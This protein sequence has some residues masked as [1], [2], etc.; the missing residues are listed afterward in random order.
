MEARVPLQPDIQSLA[1]GLGSVLA[2]QNASE[3]TNLDRERNAYSSGSFSEIV[4]CQ[5]ADGR[6]LRLFFKYA[7]FPFGADYHDASHEPFE[8]MPWS[9]VPYE[10][11]VYRQVLEPLRLSTPKFYGTYN[12]PDTGRLWLVLEH[13]ENAIPLDELADTHM[14]LA[15]S[16]LGRFHAAAEPL[17]TT[18]SPPFLKK[19]DT[20]YYLAFARRA[21]SAKWLDPSFWWLPDLC[22]RFRYIVASTLTPRPTIVHGDYYRNNI[23]LSDGNIHPVDW[24]QAA[25]G[26][27]ELDLACLTFRWPAEI[28]QQCEIEYQKS[29]WPQGAPAD[30]EVVLNAA[31]LVLYL[32]EMRNLPNWPDR[33]DRLVFG[34]EMRSLGEHLKLI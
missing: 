20:E 16:W 17:A 2:S 1:L 18:T 29:R 9:N 28:A 34:E 15:S 6:A 10:A 25:I 24:E 19:I 8:V 32:D 13:L 33:N 27:G 3:L 14:C 23:L 4:T 26:L 11:E 7:Q 30:F 31:R 5:F 22:W 21:L 12:E